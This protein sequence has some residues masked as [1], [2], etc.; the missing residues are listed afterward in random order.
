M[1]RFKRTRKVVKFFFDVPTWMGTSTIKENTAYLKNLVKKVYS[2]NKRIVKRET[3]E[4]AAQRLNLD[5]QAIKSR[6]QELKITFILSML[7]GGFLFPYSIY[8]FLTGK[9]INGIMCL[10]LTT[11]CFVLAFRYHFWMFQIERHK[12]GCSF[13]D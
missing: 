6:Y 2:F 1:P 4:E 13:K 12:L 9:F 3:F 5:E 7:A 11:L 10:A 8:V